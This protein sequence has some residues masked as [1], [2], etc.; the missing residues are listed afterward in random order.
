MA[1]RVVFSDASPL[2]ALSLVDGLGW[3]Q[4]LFGVVCITDVVAEELLPGSNRPG[5]TEIAAAITGVV[6]ISL[7]ISGQSLLFLLSMRAKEAPC[8]PR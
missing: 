2:I 6:S 5:E 4:N 7:R 1:Q 8:V 3:L